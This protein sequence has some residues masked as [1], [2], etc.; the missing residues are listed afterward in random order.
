MGAD[1]STSDRGTMTTILGLALSLLLVDTLVV[2]RAVTVDVGVAVIRA[3][4]LALFADPL[5][6]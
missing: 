1:S 2:P 3:R 6:T 5:V 4:A